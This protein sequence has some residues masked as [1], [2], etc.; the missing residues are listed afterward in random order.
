MNQTKHTIQ[1]RLPVECPSVHAKILNTQETPSPWWGTIISFAVIACLAIPATERLRQDGFPTTHDGILHLIRAILLNE[2]FREGIFYPR[3][4][5]ELYL[6]FGYPVF[7]YYAPLFYYVV[8]FLH[9]LGASLPQAILNTA[10]LY[11]VLAGWGMYMLGRDV[12]R[13][14]ELPSHLAGLIA[15]TAYIYSPYFMTNIYIRGAYPEVG[16]QALFP[17]IIFGIRRLIIT[18]RPLPYS[19]LLVLSLAGLALTHNLSLLIFPPILV[20]YSVL[21]LWHERSQGRYRHI[22]T[23]WLTVSVLAATGLSAFFWM[24][25]LIQYPL[26]QSPI[27]LAEGLAVH[28]INWDT[29]INPHIPFRYGEAVPHRIGI[30]QLIVALL[31]A[32]LAKHRRVDWWMWIAVSMLSIILMTPIVSLIWESQNITQTI[33]FPWRLLSL[34]GF[35]FAVLSGA[36][37]ARLGA[38]VYRF[39]AAFTVVSLLILSNRLVLSPLWTIVPF[40][41][42]EA[43]SDN[44]AAFEQNRQA[45]GGG[46]HN[47]F[48][49]RWA[50]A[51]ST[52]DETISPVDADGMMDLTLNKASPLQLELEST[53]ITTATLVLQQFF[54]P[55]WQVTIDSGDR[56]ETYPTKSGLLAFD[57]P[58]GVHQIRL[59][60]SGTS[61]HHASL[62]LTVFSS[63]A[64]GLILWRWAHGRTWFVVFVLSAGLGLVV[65]M[66]EAPTARQVQYPVEAVPDE[67]NVDLLGYQTKLIEGDSL[68]VYPYWRT[69][70]LAPDVLMRWELVDNEGVIY[71]VADG[72]PYY[73]TL[74]SR[75]WAPTAVVLDAQRLILPNGIHPGNYQL[76]LQMRKGD[77]QTSGDPSLLIG[78]VHLPTDTGSELPNMEIEFKFESDDKPVLLDGYRIRVGSGQWFTH[79]ELMDSRNYLAANPGDTVEITLY[80]RTDRNITMN[81]HSFLH[82]VDTEREVLTAKDRMP[83]SL[84][85]PPNRWNIYRAASDTYRLRIPDNA[86]GGLYFPRIGLYKYESMNRMTITTKDGIE[87][88]DA[89]DLIPIKVVN[90][91]HVAPANA[92]NAQ[93]AEIATLI[94]F[95]IVPERAEFR[96]GDTIDLT[97]Y[98]RSKQLTRIGY[99]R[100]AHLFADGLGMAAQSDSQPQE[101]GNPTSSWIPGEVIVD[102]VKLMLDP[103]AEP[104]TYLLSAGFYAPDAPGT[105][106]PAFD[107]SGVSQPNQQIFLRSVEIVR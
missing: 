55:G 68:Y 75:Q 102:R 22:V 11:V 44:I 31:G 9:W 89:I 36:I 99:T 48:M 35:S 100:F 1:L 14:K 17:W 8:E 64:F 30:I 54:F 92:V 57:M 87:I 42:I 12:W 80:W 88:G 45:L 3:W 23:I 50:G 21:L 62:W 49:P 107:S 47:E 90:N 40:A 96:P 20:F 28:Q 86:P 84:L 24:P 18:G 81:L 27:P 83:G 33:Q 10:M 53:V 41:D 38:P 73:N 43:T 91:K 105:R 101:G 60:W 103:N 76:R 34:V 6:G 13:E 29:A 94:G 19:P 104:G 71:T 63:F 69:G 65:I 77:N 79:S 95:D 16:A 15:A 56:L 39:I 98:Y 26:L 66:L 82:L 51:L 37:V 7:N 74:S 85:N 4:L 70:K 97:L 32:I 46:W 106:L 52:L 67:W 58:P 25:M 61:I 78:L 2:Y 72:K 5:S 59:L 93:F